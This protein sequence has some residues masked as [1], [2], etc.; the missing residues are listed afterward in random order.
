MYRQMTHATGYVSIWCFNDAA[1]RAFAVADA[2]GAKALVVDSADS[3]LVPFYQ[4][5]GFRAQF[6]G[7]IARSPLRV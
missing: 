3:S 7:R 5:N 6:R 2:I 1:A 4:C